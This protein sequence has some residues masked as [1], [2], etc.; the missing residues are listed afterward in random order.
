M[1][2]PLDPVFHIIIKQTASIAFLLNFLVQSHFA[3]VHDCTRVKF[4]SRPEDY[5]VGEWIY[6]LEL[7]IKIWRQWIKILHHK[8]KLR[9]GKFLN[10]K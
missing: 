3:L 5:L 6:V 2:L 8:I 7:A 10:K 4:I 1:S 9:C